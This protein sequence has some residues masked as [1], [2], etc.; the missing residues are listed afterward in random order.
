MKNILSI[1]LLVILLSNCEKEGVIEYPS[2]GEFGENLL[3]QDKSTYNNANFSLA[4]NLSTDS[5]VK[6]QISDKL[7]SQA[8]GLWSFP[9][10]QYSNWTHTV[11]NNN[12]SQTFTT[13]SNE[14]KCDM[15]IHFK[16]GIYKIA[17]FLNDS[18]ETAFEKIISIV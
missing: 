14:K 2:H 7:N 16:N 4:V 18:E 15:S 5:K 8:F 1:I 9:S 13:K 12:N 11:Y 10:F 3:A 17:Y 6:I